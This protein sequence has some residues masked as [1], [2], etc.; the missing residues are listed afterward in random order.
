MASKGGYRKPSN[1]AVVS[2]PG[3]LSR[4][5]DGGPTQAA[6][7]I[8]GGKYGEGQATLD[9]QRQAPMAGANAAP[10]VAT[11]VAPTQPIKTFDHPSEFPDRPITHGLPVGEGAGIE[12]SVVANPKSASDT[13]RML[14][15]FDNSG[16]AEALANILFQ[17]GS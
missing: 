8:A 9:M 16:E 13:M 2:G 1:P 17:R 15:N 5:T 4:R 3:S 10:M 6:R 11:N 7:Y 12:A 14:S